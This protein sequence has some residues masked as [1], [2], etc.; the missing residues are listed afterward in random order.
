MVLFVSQV[1]TELS[2]T[3]KIGCV[4]SYERGDIKAIANLNDYLF[5]FF[6]LPSGEAFTTEARPCTESQ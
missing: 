5:V 4:D 3:L 6:F 1:D 2:F